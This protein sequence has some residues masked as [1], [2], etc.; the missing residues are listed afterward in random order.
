[1]PDSDSSSKN[2][3]GHHVRRAREKSH[4][5]KNGGNGGAQGHKVGVLPKAGWH[6]RNFSFLKERILP[7]LFQARAGSIGKFQVPAMDENE[8]SLTWIGHASFLMHASGQNILVDPNW[9]KWLS[10]VKR[11]RQPGLE[12]HELPDIDLVLITHAHFDHLHRRTLREVAADQPIVVPRGV[13]K[14]VHDLGFRDVHELGA[15]E[16]YQHGD[17][18]ITL[19]PCLHWGARMVHDNHREFGG[20]LVEGSGRTILHGGDS[21]Y[22]EGFREIG[23]RFDIDVAILPIGAYGAPSGRDVHM[24]P[25]EAVEAFIDLKAKH[26]VPMHY[27]TFPLG[28]E[29]MSEP[30]H[31]LVACAMHRGIP[32]RLSILSEGMPR[33]F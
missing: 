10:I 18:K 13:S 3:F 5:L 15:W 8:V 11:V 17:L 33:V 31:R 22:F 27:G 32:N 30:L 23:D 21:A 9:A 29:P 1:M 20:Y 14:L 4:S 28:T 24:N 19:T 26:L 12:L 16:T 25:E 2:K 7:S 6:R